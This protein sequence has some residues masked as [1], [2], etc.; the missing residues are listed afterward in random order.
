MEHV[1]I[2]AREY[3]T[4]C[5][6]HGNFQVVCAERGAR[7]VVD[8]TPVEVGARGSMPATTDIQTSSAACAAGHAREQV[9]R[10]RSRRWTATGRAIR[11]RS[12]GGPRGSNA[13]MCRIPKILAHDTQLGLVNPHDLSGWARLL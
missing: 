11:C 5:C 4:V 3:R 6:N 8:A 7:V 12:K 10:L 1:L 9:L 2:D 13:S